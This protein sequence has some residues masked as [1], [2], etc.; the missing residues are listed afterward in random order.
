MATN[1]GETGRIFVDGQETTPECKS[2]TG[3][4][5]FEKSVI[6]GAVPKVFVTCEALYP[7]G[8]ALLAFCGGGEGCGAVAAGGHQ[9]QVPAL[10]NPANDDNDVVYSSGT[11]RDSNIISAPTRA[12]DKNHLGHAIGIPKWKKDESVIFFTRAPAKGDGTVHNMLSNEFFEIRSLFEYAKRDFLTSQCHGNTYAKT[13]VDEIL[14]SYD[15]NSAACG[16]RTRLPDAAF[17]GN[18]KN[19]KVQGYLRKADLLMRILH[20]H[21]HAIEYTKLYIKENPLEIRTAAH[22]VLDRL[23]RFLDT[24]GPEPLRLYLKEDEKYAGVAAELAKLLPGLLAGPQPAAGLP[25]V[26]PLQ[27]QYEFSRV[28]NAF[29]SL[30][31]SPDHLTELLSKFSQE[32]DPFKIQLYGL[33]KDSTKEPGQ[34]TAACDSNAAPRTVVGD[35][36]EAPA[37]PQT[38]IPPKKKQKKSLKLIRDCPK[39][40]G[41]NDDRAPTIPAANRTSKPWID[42]HSKVKYQQVEGSDEQKY[43]HGTT[44]HNHSARIS[45]MMSV[46]CW[47]QK[48]LWPGPNEQGKTILQHIAG[49]LHENFGTEAKEGKV[50]SPQ[51]HHHAHT[52]TKLSTC[53]TNRKRSPCF[54]IPAAPM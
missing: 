34:Q 4:W 46:I 32:M 24:Y 51:P 2:I 44:A 47:M 7:P 16:T 48:S 52:R 14:G 39:G 40:Q 20:F 23:L 25:S 3:K 22:A 31:A 5:A 54:H 35:K 36:R 50:T 29:R 27:Q 8:D 19:T 15:V 30:S 11:H 26:E 18:I 49:F 38:D 13:I 41:F 53:E 9:P 43:Q 45:R 17:N 33:P 1:G 21:K 28:A 12:V 37:A 6:E 10:Q 42:G